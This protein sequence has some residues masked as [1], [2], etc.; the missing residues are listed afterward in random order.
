MPPRSS[1]QTLAHLSPASG[2]HTDFSNPQDIPFTLSSS[3]AMIRCY[4]SLYEAYVRLRC[5]VC[6]QWTGIQQAK[7]ML[8]CRPYLVD[9]EQLC[10][11]LFGAGG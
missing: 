11:V 2:P 10:I 4:H 8:D 1:A 6:K 7:V 3:T 5:E 9:F